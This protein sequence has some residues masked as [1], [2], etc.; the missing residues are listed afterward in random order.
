MDKRFEELLTP[1]RV[2]ER[3]TILAMEKPEWVQGGDWSANRTYRRI[4]DQQR[5]TQQEQSVLDKREALSQL[6]V[7]L[8]ELKDAIGDKAQKIQQFVVDNDLESIIDYSNWDDSV[9]IPK[10]LDSDPV[11]SAL[12]WAAS[13]H[14]C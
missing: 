13:D 2:A 6:A 14:S 5:F 3:A 4:Q 12:S 11:G 7:M 1:T 9:D 8:E 10:M